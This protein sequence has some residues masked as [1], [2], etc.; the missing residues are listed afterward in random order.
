MLGEVALRIYVASRGWT[1]N[2]YATGLA[3]F[4]PHDTAGYALRAGLRLR[5][6]SYDVSVNS[7]GFRGPE[8]ARQLP[9]DT[10]RIAVLGGSSV[11]GYLV[12]EGQDSCRE[13]EKLLAQRG[14]SSEVINAG[15]PGYNM[16]Q[17]REHYIADVA[18]LQPDF[19]ILCLGWNDSR[20]LVSPRAAELERRPPA[21]PLL[22]RALSHSALFGFLRYRLLPRSTPKFAPPADSQSTVNAAGAD[23]FSREYRALIEAIRDSDAVPIVS[24]QVMAAGQGCSGLDKYLGE[25]R[26]QI[27]ANRAIGQ[28]ITRCI[29]QTAVQEQ[30]NII[31]CAADLPCDATMLGDAIHLTKHGHQLVAELW[32]QEL[33]K[34]VHQD[35]NTS[36]TNKN[37]AHER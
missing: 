27:E 5:S 24:T 32:C 9:K 26:A 3:F 21:P 13:L 15:V 14:L 35:A 1:P 2:C 18:P 7:A 28:W 33:L 8:L 17:C 4:V 25:T 10:A 34:I 23:L 12:P 16:T 22:Q 29:R 30:V 36:T 6:S 31:D 37:V 19:V 11:F 20:L